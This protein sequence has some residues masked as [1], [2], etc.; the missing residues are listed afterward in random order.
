MPYNT[1][2]IFVTKLKIFRRTDRLA[3]ANLNA[4][5]LEWGH[6][7]RCTTEKTTKSLNNTKCKYSQVLK[8]LKRYVC[9]IFRA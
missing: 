1:N 6:N 5:V 4:S 2:A 9:D 3:R 8:A 7:N